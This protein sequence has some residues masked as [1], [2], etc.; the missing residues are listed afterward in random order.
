M[1]TKEANRKLRAILSTDV[2][3]SNRLI[4]K[5]EVGALQFFNT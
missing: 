5:D 4:A 2:K 1:A 3:G